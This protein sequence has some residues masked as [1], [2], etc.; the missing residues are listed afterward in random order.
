[1]QEF[2]AA[3]IGT[4]DT[5]QYTYII[6]GGLQQNCCGG[7]AEKSS[8]TMQIYAD[9]CNRTM[10]VSPS[11]QTCALGSS[12]F[13]AVVGGAYPDVLSAQK[14]MTP[15]PKTVYTPNADAARVYADLFD[16]YM[17]LHDGFGRLGARDL[18]GVMS[19]LIEIRNA[20][21]A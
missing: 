8:L 14:A 21:R 7:I 5:V 2:S 20:A 16:L 15:E 1:M 9:V 19:R 6:C 11:A 4:K 13:G 10:T 3:A 18:S 17:E 12:I